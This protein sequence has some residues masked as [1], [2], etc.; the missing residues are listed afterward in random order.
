MNHCVRTNS[1]NEN[2][3]MLVR[4]LDADLGI[5]DG[6]DHLFYAR[7]NTID[8][9]R[10]AIVAYD[11][12]TPVGCG[13]IKEY[14]QDT[15]EVKRMYVAVNWRG[16]GIATTILKELERWAFELNYKKCLLETGKKQPEAIE[17]YKKNGYQIIPNFGQ[18]KNVENSVC[19]EK[20]F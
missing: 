17:L 7:F 11:S 2:F 20:I 9:I 13:A 4:E 1:S 16:K 3:Q 14:S 15:M 5:R 12:E 6:E 19:F 10:Y 18:Y 8:N